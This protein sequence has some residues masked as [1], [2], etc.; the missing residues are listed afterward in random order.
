ME[1][2]KI[3]IIVEIGKTGEVLWSVKY[4]SYGNRVMPLFLQSLLVYLP[5]NF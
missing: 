2:G 4:M 1:G 3:L 5:D